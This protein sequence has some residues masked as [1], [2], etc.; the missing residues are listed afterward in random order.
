MVALLDDYSDSDADAQDNAEMNAPVE[1]TTANQSPAVRL[2]V[3]GEYAL[4]VAHDLNNVL[5]VVLANAS[6][7]ATQYPSA[8]R[9]TMPEELHD[10]IT[11]A[12]RGSEMIH[13]LIRFVRQEPLSIPPIAVDTAFELLPRQIRALLPEK[14]SLDV[15]VPSF[16]LSIRAE[17]SQIEEIVLNLVTNARD[18][19]PDGGHLEFVVSRG[20][21]G[22]SNERNASGSEREFISISVTDTGCGL[23]DATRRQMFEPFFTTKGV[24]KGLGIGLAM[25]RTLVRQLNGTIEVQTQPGCGTTVSVRLPVEQRAT[26]PSGDSIATP[27]F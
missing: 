10:I 13:R 17:V 19:M 16:P 9:A 14:I 11:S 3:V 4:G 23:D 18:A 2:A 5:M 8:T 21:R 24:G 26:E 25:T 15:K 27:L 6:M 7:L 22:A 12:E 1:R 20:H